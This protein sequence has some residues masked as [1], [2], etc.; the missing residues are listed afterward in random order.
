MWREPPNNGHTGAWVF[1]LYSEVFFIEGFD[2]LQP[3]FLG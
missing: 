3:F 1:V 2:L